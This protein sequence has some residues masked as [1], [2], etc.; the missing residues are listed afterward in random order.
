MA[1]GVAVWIFVSVPDRPATVSA[2]V[3]LREDIAVSGQILRSRAFWRYAPAVGTLS[4]FNFVYLGLW[5][6]PWLRDV[7]GIDGPGRA[8]LLFFYTAVMVAGSVAAGNLTSRARRADLPPF[9]VPVVA[10]LFMVI[11]QIG[12]IC[13]P[14]QPLWVM[15]LWLGA[16]FFGSAGPAG[17]VAIGQLFPPEQTGRISTAVNTL[18]LGLAFVVQTIYGWI[19][20][21]WPRTPLGGWHPDGYSW[22]L[23]LTGGLQL[24]AAIAMARGAPKR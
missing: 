13:Q 14:V 9:I 22:G 8:S 5:A 17:Y 3:S 2:S 18:S 10:M 12:L 4:M 6:G 1:L 7:A 23:A 19:L 16:A 21:L 24:A 20:D 15:T 11:L